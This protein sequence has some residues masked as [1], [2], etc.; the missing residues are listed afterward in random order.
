MQTPAVEQQPSLQVE[1]EQLSPAGT[2]MPLRHCSLERQVLQG[3]PPAPQAL[4]VLP[5][6]HRLLEQQPVQLAQALPSREGIVSTGAVSSEQAS[7]VEQSRARAV[8]RAKSCPRRLTGL[9][10]GGGEGYL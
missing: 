9:I 10:G 5:G 1:G 7:R 3:N 4:I 2:Q 8:E 6:R